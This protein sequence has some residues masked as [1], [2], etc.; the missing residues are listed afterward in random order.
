M[1]ALEVTGSTTKDSELQG[2]R[3][4]EVRQNGKEVNQGAER[5]HAEGDY[6][7]EQ[8]ARTPPSSATER[9]NEVYRAR[10]IGIKASNG[11]E[12]RG[13]GRRCSGIGRRGRWSHGATWR[14]QGRGRAARARGARSLREQPEVDEE[15]DKWDPRCQREKKRRGSTRKGSTRAIG[16][17]SN[18]R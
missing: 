18:G 2:T 17:R 1:H 16:S 12:G 15:D 11:R 13:V 14:K 10:E 9:R 7:R 8:L 6:P 4:A 5:N 3:G